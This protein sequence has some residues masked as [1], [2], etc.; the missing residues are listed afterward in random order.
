MTFIR[1]TDYSLVVP[2]LYVGRAPHPGV[3]VAAGVR[4]VVLCAAEFQPADE[5]IWKTYPDVRVLRCPLRDIE[6]DFAP[7]DAY[8]IAATVRAIKKDVHQGRPV[9]ITCMQ[10]LNRGPLIAAIAIKQYYGFGPSQAIQLLRQK[11]HPECLYNRKFA[12]YAL[13]N[14]VRMP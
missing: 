7:K 11:R 8:R 4:T 14:T 3:A 13:R 9:L 5:F 12:A 10:G 1:P 6:Q 2:R